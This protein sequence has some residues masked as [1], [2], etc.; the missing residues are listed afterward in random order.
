[1]T[2]SGQPTQRRVASSSSDDQD[3]AHRHVDRQ[4]IADAEGELAEDP[5]DVEGRDATAAASSQSTSE[6]LPGERQ[7]AGAPRSDQLL[8]AGKTRKIR[9]STNAMWT[10]R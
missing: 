2:G 5:R 6:M 7:F 4:R 10:P 1:M 3:R 9:P 8:R